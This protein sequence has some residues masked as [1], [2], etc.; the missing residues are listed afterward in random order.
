MNGS[1]GIGK[2]K[3]RTNVLQPTLYF[4]FA[5]SGHIVVLCHYKHK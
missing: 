2:V 1:V 5:K 4:Y 3:T